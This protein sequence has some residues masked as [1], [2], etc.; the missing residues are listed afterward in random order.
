MKGRMSE[1]KER[2]S[3]KRRALLM[4]VGYLSLAFDKLEGRSTKPPKIKRRGKIDIVQ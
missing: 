3:L 4:L 1:K 2:I